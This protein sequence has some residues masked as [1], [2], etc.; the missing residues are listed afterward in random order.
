MLPIREQ[1]GPV[2]KTYVE[3]HKAKYKNF[4]D[5]LAAAGIS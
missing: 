4:D 5:F 1:L 3:S 2:Y